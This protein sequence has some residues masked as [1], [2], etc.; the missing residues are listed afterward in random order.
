[1]TTILLK[2]STVAGH[3]PTPTD[4]VS[5]ELA[6]NSADGKAFM[7]LEDGTVKELGGGSA[8][9]TPVIIPWV[10]NP[11]WLPMPPTTSADEQVDILV[12]VYPESSYFALNFVTSPTTGYTV[13]WGDGSAPVNFASAVAANYLYDYN[14]AAL[15]GT[16]G[17]VTFTAATSTVNRTSH[18]YTNGMTISFA[19][20][21]TTTGITQLQTYYVVNATANT[22]QLSITEGGTVLPLTTDGTGTILPYKQAMVKVTP[23]VAGATLVTVNL[24]QKNSTPNLQGYNQP[25]LD[26]TISA[27]ATSLTIGATSG[28]STIPRLMERC[29]ILRAAPLSTTATFA[30]CSSLQSVSLFDTS[31]S[32]GA[33]DMF[34]GCISL[35]EIP[36]FD[37]RN[38]TNMTNMFNGCTSLK[39]VPLLNTSK[40]TSMGTATVGYGM[41][42]GCRS[43]QTVPLFDTS[44]VTNMQQMFNGCINLTSVPLFDT[45]KVTIMGGLNGGVFN[46]CNSLKEVPL[47]NTMNVTNMQKMFSSCVSLRTI[48]PFN[49]S[50]VTDMTAM[51]SS[52][53]ALISVP[54]LDTS[55]VIAMN[56]GP[57]NGIFTNCYSLQ[58]VPL[59]NT[60]KITSF[61]YMFQSCTNIGSIPPF[62]TSAVTG[63]TAFTQ[64]FL[65]CVSLQQIPD[66]NFNRAAITSSG[67]YTSL[68]NS[69]QS[70]SKLNLS[71][72]NGPKFTFS[73]ASCK[74]SAASLNQLYTSLPTVTG[75]TLTVTGNVGIAGDDPTIATQKGWTISGS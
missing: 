17:P 71:P 56:G 35:Q 50:K 9:P 54:L 2:N 43:L 22:F 57:N 15:A 59:F 26:L 64:M 53:G 4:L 12:C 41:F 27:V 67:S 60:S 37:T 70:L 11:C 36:L 51:F 62:D 29:N 5:G 34:N 42:N 49:T 74:L 65:N 23:T 18:G 13:D 69:C 45:S 24:G 21:V 66:I 47:F 73:V 68:F 25:I 61:Q 6:L 40:V 63:T 19:E 33:T 3:A 58:T 16:N 20:I 52:C 7:K 38:V 10:R 30:G 31:A 28:I 44:N 72:G 39:S 46:G 55:N 32:T 1:M 8:P 14:A 75:Q 48:P